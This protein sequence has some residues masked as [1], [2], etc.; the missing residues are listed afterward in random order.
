MTSNQDQAHFF[1]WQSRIS[2]LLPA[3]FVMQP[4]TNDQ[5]AVIHIAQSGASEIRLLT[6]C[7]PLFP[8]EQQVALRRAEQ[9]A[10][11][12]G[13]QL[14]RRETRTMAGVPAIVQQLVQHTPEGLQQRFECFA[15]A[16]DRLFS[17]T[18][19]W[20]SGEDHEL[21][22]FL[23]WLDSVRLIPL[24]EER[25]ASLDVTTGHLAHRAL[26]LSAWLPEGWI[27]FEEDSGTLRFYGPVVPGQA[28]FQPSF[29]LTLAEPDD[30]S[31]GWL[32]RMLAERRQHLL[33]QSAYQLEEQRQ[34]QLPDQLP[35]EQLHYRWQADDEHG[36]HMQQT[37]VQ[38]DYRSFY[39][40]SATTLES[41][42]AEHA[43]LFEQ[44]LNSLRFLP[45]H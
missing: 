18:C 36:F 39:L 29:S 5:N 16:H 40:I 25:P 45:S 1:N 43:P 19:D 6:R 42:A 32:E 21:A 28:G 10:Q 17:I 34:L 12:P 31:E 23:Q 13:Y 15:E 33:D 22:L 11:Q 37:F 4:V 20:P 8:G 24:S 26:R 44:M 9:T 41:M 27:P 7:Q 3:R 14:L 30:Y 38:A 2:L 35:A